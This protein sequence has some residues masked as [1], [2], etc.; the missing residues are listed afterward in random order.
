MN[1]FIV[2]Y[3]VST[4][5]QG[6]SGLGLDAQRASVERFLNGVTPLAEFTEIESGKNNDR[7]ELHRALALCRQSGA[8]LLISRLD[9]LG[10]RASFLLGLQE[11]GVKF[12][13]V[14]APYLDSFSVGILSLVAQKEAELCSS[15]TRDALAACKRRGIKLGN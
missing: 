7:K 11:S 10:R 9:R 4:A 14:D 3:R 12:T 1:K 15:R 5:R 2:Y 6:Q 13:A 8:T